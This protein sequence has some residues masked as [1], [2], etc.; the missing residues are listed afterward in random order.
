MRTTELTKQLQNLIKKDGHK[1]LLTD[2]LRGGQALTI[3]AVNKNS[4]PTTSN[5]ADVK[6]PVFTPP[7]ASMPPPVPANYKELK[8]RVVPIPGAKGS[9]KFPAGPVAM[10]FPLGKIGSTNANPSGSVQVD[11]VPAIELSQD[12]LEEKLRQRNEAC[13]FPC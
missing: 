9:L 7:H 8:N 13:K 10:K 3:D 12:M 5:F 11:H 6:T 2:V 1:T 4:E